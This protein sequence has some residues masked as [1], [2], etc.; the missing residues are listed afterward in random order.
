VNK[1]TLIVGGLIGAGVLW[2]L[3]G[4]R[5]GRQQGFDDVQIDPALGKH[6]GLGVILAGI[7][8]L[9]VRMKSAQD[10]RG[11]MADYLSYPYGATEPSRYAMG[12]PAQKVGSWW[13]KREDQWAFVDFSPIDYGKPP[14]RIPKT[15]KDANRYWDGITSYGG[16][17]VVGQKVHLFHLRPSFPTRGARSISGSL[18]PVG[19]GMST[20]SRARIPAVF[21]PSAVA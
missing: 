10:P 19:G 15:W 3:M 1:A 4:T 5:G 14:L 18:A 8:Q 21:V 12:E 11:G 6:R 9:P 17:D 2:V 13:D 20:A 7:D 16:T